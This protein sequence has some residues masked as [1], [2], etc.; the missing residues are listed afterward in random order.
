MPITKWVKR[1]IL[2]EAIQVHVQ[3]ESFQDAR[4]WLNKYKIFHQWDNWGID[5][6]ARGN[7][8]RVND[9]DYLV[10]GIE[11]WDFYPVKKETFEAIYEPYGHFSDQD[12]TDPRQGTLFDLL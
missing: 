11:D 7:S 4:D 5:F 2:T 9:G 8:L 12:E 1:P 3:T 10:K 6:S